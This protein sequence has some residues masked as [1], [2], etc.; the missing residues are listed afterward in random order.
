MVKR[1]CPD[2]GKGG[3]PPVDA[4]RLR[5]AVSRIAGLRKPPGGWPGK[6]PKEVRADEEEEAGDG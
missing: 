2:E 4:G 1:E 5:D 3:L 6:P